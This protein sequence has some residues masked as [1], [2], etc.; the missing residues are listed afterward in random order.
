MVVVL[1][2]AALVA[3]ACG[4]DEG[5][6]VDSDNSESAALPDRPD[7]PVETERESLSWVT[8]DG[9]SWPLDIV[10]PVDQVEGGWPV[11]VTFHGAASGTS[12]SELAGVAR[13]GVVVVGPRWATPEW[14]IGNLGAI[15]AADYVDGAVFDGAKCA[16]AAAQAAAADHGGNPDWTTVEG[17]SAGVHA[18]AWV[19]LGVVRND[20]CPDA[21]IVAPVAM[22]VGDSQWVFQGVFGDEWD[23]AF[24]D[25]S[26]R[27][28]DTVD[29][30]LNPERW[31]GPDGF[32]AYLWSSESTDF[33]RPVE[34]PPAA[35]SWLRTRGGDDLIEDLDTVGGFDDG[36]IGFLDNGLLQEYR[37]QQAGLA[38]VH[39]QH[40]GGH[41][42]KP[43]AIERTI[44]LVWQEP[45]G[46]SCPESL[47]PA[48]STMIRVVARRGNT[49]L[50]LCTPTGG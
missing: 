37:M 10:H 2:M 26:S 25:E 45:I 6:D 15:G 13:S 32:E 49:I 20:P 1:L 43:Q 24:A 18:A 40:P 29:R 44:E 48:H 36:A 34:N 38:V 39:E 17:F 33:D 5:E 3:G 11:L 12:A 28:P 4:D 35:D 27:A 47:F 19:G 21:E 16:L 8:P 30:F 42:R 31:D 50:G 46:D 41:D 23:A 14:T 9:E 7:E 22:V